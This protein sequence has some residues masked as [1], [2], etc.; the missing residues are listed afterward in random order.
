MILA[1]PLLSGYAFV[2]AAAAIAAKG[3]KLLRRLRHS[4]YCSCRCRPWRPADSRPI[5]V[6]AGR[7]LAKIGFTDAHATNE[8]ASSPSFVGACCAFLLTVWLFHRLETFKG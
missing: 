8:N 3:H 5:C 6:T 4:P 2:A 7:E 1:H